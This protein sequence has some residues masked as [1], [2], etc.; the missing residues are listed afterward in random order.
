MINRLA[1][2]RE[3]RGAIWH[4]T[5]T[6]CGANG[7]TQVRFAGFTEFTLATLCGVQRNNVIARL[8]AG[9]AF[10]HF[11]HHTAAFMP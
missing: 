5:F 9:D 2:I 8:Q 4:Q 3:A 11:N 1:V 7:L 10:A 6:L